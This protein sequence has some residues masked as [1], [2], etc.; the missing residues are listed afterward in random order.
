M[1]MRLTKG[2][3]INLQGWFTTMGRLIMGIILQVCSN[4]RKINGTSST[5]QNLHRS[6]QTPQA[7]LFIYCFTNALKQ[8]QCDIV[9]FPS[10]F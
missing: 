8:Q 3:G 10:I 6:H 1:C 7:E 2:V 9:I 5:T 4:R